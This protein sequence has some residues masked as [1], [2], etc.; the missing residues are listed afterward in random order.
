[1]PPPSKLRLCLPRPVLGD[2]GA[3]V[4]CDNDWKDVLGRISKRYSKLETRSKKKTA[5]GKY[6][7]MA[8]N[9][10][11]TS[12]YDTVR[13]QSRDLIQEL[14]KRPS[15]WCAS[16][17]DG[18]NGCRAF[19]MKLILLHG[20]KPDPYAYVEITENSHVDFMHALLSS[21]P[22]C[23]SQDEWTTE[24][25]MR[26]LRTKKFRLPAEPI[27]G[28]G[29][30]LSVHLDDAQSREVFKLIADEVWQ[31]ALDSLNASAESCAAS[32]R[33]AASDD[34][35]KTSKSSRS[36]V[37]LHPLLPRHADHSRSQTQEGTVYTSS[38]SISWRHQL[39]QAQ[40]RYL[41]ITSK[42]SETHSIGYTRNV[43][44]WNAGT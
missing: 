34:L 13:N 10:T 27:H 7:L 44:S 42:R 23:T 32:T 24:T 40:Q 39:D 9:V 41:D 18:Q 26:I 3:S 33:A 4:V 5:G 43:Q 25:I 37:S 12:K 36:M 38:T 2:V 19:K 29:L 28:I 21:E 16:F 17:T 31:G 20:L 8:S 6:G 30:D 22:S 11:E 15:F 1:M 14:E 35:D